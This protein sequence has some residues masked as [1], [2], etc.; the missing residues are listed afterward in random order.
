MFY[1]KPMRRIT[2]IGA[3][4]SASWAALYL[5]RGFDV[6]ETNPSSNAESQYVRALMW[7]EMILL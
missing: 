4:L 7:C 2:I 1:N 5:A 6:I 3:G